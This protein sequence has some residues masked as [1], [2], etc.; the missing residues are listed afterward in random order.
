MSEFEQCSKRLQLDL[1]SVLVNLSYELGK[2]MT[3]YELMDARFVILFDLLSLLVK[4]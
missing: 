4:L 1:I 3:R 2:I